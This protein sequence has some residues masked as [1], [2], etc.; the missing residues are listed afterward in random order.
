[1]RS[2]IVL[3]TLAG[4][5]GFVVFKQLPTGDAQADEDARPPSQQIQS[6]SIDGGRGLPLAALRAVLV[7]RPGEP[8]DDAKLDQDRTALHAELAARGYLAALVR[9]AVV[10]YASGA[11]V[12]FEIDAGVVFKIRDVKVVGASDKDAVITISK[13]DEA[14]A[15]RIESARQVLAENL[16]RHGKK[17]TVTV[18]IEKDIANHVVDVTLRTN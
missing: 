9:P 3:L 8:V 1:M 2:L 18:S 14:L 12:V 13:G 16:A 7:S 11:Y 10:T 4:I 15:S 17:R 5:A 6:I